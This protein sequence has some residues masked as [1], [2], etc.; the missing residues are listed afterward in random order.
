M[1]NLGGCLAA[2]AGIRLDPSCLLG[3][4][5][6]QTEL[7]RSANSIRARPTVEPGKDI[8]HVHVHGG[9]TQEDVIRDL[10]VRFA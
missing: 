4:A 5:L 10:F 7:A 6:E 3:A 8:A 1:T 9:W 2:K